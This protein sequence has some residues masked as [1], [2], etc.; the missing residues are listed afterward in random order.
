MVRPLLEIRRDELREYLRTMGQDWR[1]DLSN[2]DLSRLRARLRHRELPLIERELQPAIVSH[3]CQL[4]QL[5]REDEAFW[6]AL[7]RERLNALAQRDGGRVGIRCADLLA[8]VAWPFE[9]TEASLAL[10]RRLVRGL[11]DEV[12]GNGRG[13]TAQHVE[14][15]LQ[16]ATTGA[17]GRRTQL[18]GAVVERSFDWI[19]FA[20]AAQSTEEL[21]DEKDVFARGVELG[22]VGQVTVVAVPEI[23]TRFRLKVFDWAAR[24]RETTFRG[25]LDLD[26]LRPPLVLRNWRPGDS[27]QPQGR[28]HVLKLKQLLRETRIA[29]RDRTGWPVLTSAGSVV[30]ARGCPVA[31]E[32]AARKSTRTGVVVAEEE[33]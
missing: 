14:Q 6:V 28:G 20:P 30:W 11:L 16:L 17:S 32:F 31:A 22:L 15:V 33:I 13:L 26:L 18:P 23:G 1:E 12:R 2:Q 5:S 4:A 9:S 7:V 8:P 25:A 27:F 10:T 21:K 24:E 3:L 29:V 19:W